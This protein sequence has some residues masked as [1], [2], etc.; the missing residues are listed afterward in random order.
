LGEGNAVFSPSPDDIAGMQIV[1]VAAFSPRALQPLELR[2]LGVMSDEDVL[3]VEF[4]YL[5][6]DLM[7]FRLPWMQA[8]FEAE[9]LVVGTDPSSPQPEAIRDFVVSLLRSIEKPS[10]KAVGINRDLHFPVSDERVW[11]EVGHKLAPKA[12]LWDQVLGSPGM[13]A[14]S[15]SGLRKDGTA[16]KMTVRVEPSRRLKFGIYVNVNDHFIAE[17]ASPEGSARWFADLLQSNWL[18]S[19]KR[20]NEVFAMLQGVSKP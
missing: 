4:D 16:G 9:R 17:E 14:I 1:V 5:F 3:K 12:G 2:R 11:H 15:V 6:E 8:T 7:A 10:I 18:A 19:E 13:E 20:A